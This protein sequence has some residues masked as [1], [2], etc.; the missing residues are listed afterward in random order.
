MSDYQT[1][2]LD[3]ASDGIAT[4]TLNRPEVLNALNAEMK[5]EL[6]DAVTRLE[7]DD[8]VRCVLLA[9]AGR[10]FMAGGDVKRFYEERDRD[11]QWKRR[12]FLE[13]INAMHPIMFSLR[14][15]PKP[16]IAAVQGY[17]VGFGM[18]LALGCD[19][20]ICADSA[21][22]RLAYVGI[23]TS[24]DGSISYTL[25]RLVGLKKALEFAILGDD[26]TAGEA[27]SLGMVNYVVPEA[28]LPA[29]AAKLAARLAA[30]PTRAIAGIKALMHGSIDTDYEAQLQKEAE[31]F[32]EN[33][34]GADFREGVTAF[35]EKRQ[36]QFK[37]RW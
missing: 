2:K 17:A 13:G 7:F 24:P 18:S 26:V 10:H 11:L 1:I 3:L 27:L 30:G 32:A 37:G 12:R 22:F 20:T 5:E 28:E 4:L 6:A 15:M 35:A 25:P 14:R 8:A 21:R 29:E 19:L 16:T 36:P 23:G 31:T 33:A 34:V 9:G